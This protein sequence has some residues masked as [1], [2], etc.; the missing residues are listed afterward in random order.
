MMRLIASFVVSSLFTVVVLAQSP[1]PSSRPPTTSSTASAPTGGT[2]AEGK[3]AVVNLAQFREGVNELKAR[4]DA[5]NVELEPTWKEMKTL[6]DELTKLK[7]QLET[8]GNTVSAQVRNQWMEQAA[9]KER[10]YKRKGEDYQQLGQKRYLQVSQPIY[11][12]ILKFL[13]RYCTE[14]G[15]VMVLELGAASQAGI[16]FYAAPATDITEDFIKEYNKANPVASSTKP[17]KAGGS[18]EFEF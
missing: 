16:L 13:E 5:L 3:L 8:K 9:E 14:R 11:D 1:K 17:P 2:G 18:T 12:K 7:N 4:I 15:I 10:L 6:E